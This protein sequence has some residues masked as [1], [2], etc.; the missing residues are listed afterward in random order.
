MIS[1]VRHY[2]YCF[3]KDTNKVYVITRRYQSDK[4]EIMRRMIYT[5]PLKNKWT[6]DINNVILG[7]T[8]KILC[9]DKLIKLLDS[10]DDKT[11]N[12]NESD[13]MYMKGISVRLNMPIKVI[14]NVHCDIETKEEYENIYYYMF[15]KND[16]EYSK[17]W[18][19][20]IK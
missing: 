13:I 8:N 2:S 15:K 4:N 11:I 14:T 12:I 3:L 5:E 20:I 1:N 9:E 18:M 7:Y 16:D 10:F 19:N 17:E 6:G